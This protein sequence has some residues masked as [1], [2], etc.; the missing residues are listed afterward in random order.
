MKRPCS[1]LFKTNESRKILTSFFPLCSP[2]DSQKS[3]DYG[4]AG[5]VTTTPTCSSGNN[6]S[7]NNTGRT[8][9]TTKQ[10]TEL[11]KEFYYNKYLTRARRIEIATS[12]QLN[13]TQVKIW[14]QNRRMK[15]KKREKEKKAAGC[16]VDI[17]ADVTT[18]PPPVSSAT[19]GGGSGG[20]GQS[21]S[22]SSNGAV[23]GKGKPGPHQ[24][25]TGTGNSIHSDSSNPAPSPALSNLT[26]DAKYPVDITGLPMKAIG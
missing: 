20:G 22:T 2:T 12:L 4:Y 19:S 13:E 9:F 24:Q 11:E 15:Q 21:D 7:A 17:S 18:S 14:F 8:N 26:N 5:Q 23:S 1:K 6:A 25:S 10:L 3:S 16:G